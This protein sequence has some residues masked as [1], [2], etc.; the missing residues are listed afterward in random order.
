MRD[1]VIIDGVRTPFGKMGGSLRDYASTELAAVAIKGLLDRVGIDKLPID[2]VFAGSALHDSKANNP[3]RY[4]S[5]LAGLPY[6]VAASYV[7]MQCGSAIDAMNHAAWRILAGA[8]DAMIVGGMESYSQCTVRFSMAVEPYKLIPPMPL[9]MALAPDPEQAVNMIEVSENMATKWGITKTACDEFAYRSQKRANKAVEDGVIGREIVPVVKPATKKTPEIRI[10]ADEQLRP[11]T[12]LEGL[13]KLP[14]VSGEGCV[15]SAGNASGRNDGAA[16]VLMMSG[17]AAARYGLKP[18]A[19]WVWG[20]DAGVEPK[21]MGIGPAYANLKVMKHMGLSI[22]DIGVFECNEAFAVQNL[23]V[24]KEMETQTGKK[25]DPS[26][27]NPNGG[28][29]SFGHPNGASGARIAIFAMTQL[30]HTGG[31]YGLISSC[32]GGGLGV[33]ALLENLT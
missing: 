15:T 2:S 19:R 7:E 23:G 1:V 13:A 26:K 22:G 28:A 29:I 24:I 27:W 8:A 6:E 10:T 4:A 30:E 21:Y 5:L 3:A 17:E 9:S 33:A 12:T 20:S 32:C 18:R 11:D 31:K 14:A 25:I 16:F